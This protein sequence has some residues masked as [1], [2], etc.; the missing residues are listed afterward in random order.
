MRNGILGKLGSTGDQSR[1]KS[2]D[3]LV[4][5]E[6]EVEMVTS[7]GFPSGVQARPGGGNG[8]PIYPF[9][10]PEIPIYLKNAKRLIPNT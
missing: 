5:V 2:R 7:R 8:I 4:S 10:S 6:G 1:T 3:S 9:F